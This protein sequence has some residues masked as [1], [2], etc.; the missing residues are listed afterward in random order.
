MA[1]TLLLK[2]KHALG[3][4]TIGEQKHIAKDDIG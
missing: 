1:V 4:G 3:C 2:L